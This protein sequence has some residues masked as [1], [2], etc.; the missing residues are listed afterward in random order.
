MQEAVQ[1]QSSVTVAESAL[2]YSTNA[3]GRTKAFNKAFTKAFNKA[4]NKAFN[5]A[6]NKDGSHIGQQTNQE[7]TG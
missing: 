5:R 1:F 6:F 7:H 2:K 3:G 4:S